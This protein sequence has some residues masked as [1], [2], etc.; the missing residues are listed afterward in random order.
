MKTEKQFHTISQ[1]KPSLPVSRILRGVKKSPYCR[2]TLQEVL[3]KDSDSFFQGTM[4]TTSSLEMTLCS[5]Q[6]GSLRDGEHVLLLGLL[7][8]I[9]TLP[10]FRH[11][12]SDSSEPLGMGL[13]RQRPLKQRHFLWPAPLGP[14]PAAAKNLKEF[15][16][17]SRKE[18]K[19]SGPVNEGLM[20]QRNQRQTMKGSF[21]CRGEKNTT[22][23]NNLLGSYSALISCFIY[24]CLKRRGNF[25]LF[26][27]FPLILFKLIYLLS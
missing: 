14:T 11:S 2:E 18:A 26:S 19:G 16:F 5:K 8:P 1:I 9:Q 4:P 3:Q 23:S 15:L 17:Q 12:L 20:L 7:F 6:T 13:S 22:T 10:S 21:G 27:S 24:D 25:F